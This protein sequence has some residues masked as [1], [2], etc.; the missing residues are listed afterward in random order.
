M[1]FQLFLSIVSLQFCLP[2][3]C[4]PCFQLFLFRFEFASVF[5]FVCFPFSTC[6]HRFGIF[7]VD[8]E[9]SPVKR[10][11]QLRAPVDLEGFVAKPSGSVVS[12]VY[13]RT[14]QHEAT[15]GD[16]DIYVNQLKTQVLYEAIGEE[17]PR[18]WTSAHEKE[19]HTPC[20]SE[21]FA[22]VCVCCHTALWAHFPSNS[23]AG[24][25]S[26]L[27]WR[28]GVSWWPQPWIHYSE[29]A[30]RTSVGLSKAIAVTTYAGVM[31]SF[32]AVHHRH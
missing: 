21:Y 29:L 31:F 20:L 32:C 2:R 3:T 26:V 22:L 23:P 30:Y 15:F 16:R 14:M 1:W 12:G 24:G 6:Y 25:P 11:S 10:E 8:P 9:L 4:S 27:L 17:S 7:R 5:Y 18:Q 28:C 13:V 19:L